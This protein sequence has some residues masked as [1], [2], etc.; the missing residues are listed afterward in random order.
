MAPDDDV[1]LEESVDDIDARRGEVSLAEGADFVNLV[2]AK[3]C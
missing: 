2:D 3:S 1:H